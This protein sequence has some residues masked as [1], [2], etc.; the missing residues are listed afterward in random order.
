MECRRWPAYRAPD[1]GVPPLYDSG[2]K[3]PEWRG[4]RKPLLAILLVLLGVVAVAIRWW[5]SYV[6]DGLERWAVEEVTRRTD[7][8]YRLALDQ[9]SFRPLAGAISFDSAAVVT[10][11]TRNRRRPVPLPVLR[12]LAHECRVSGLNLVRLLLAR[13]F[14]AR[15][16]ECRRVV[17]RITINPPARGDTGL[18]T[19]T[20]GIATS[21]RQLA[22]PLG[23]AAFRVAAVSFPSFS[24]TMER[25]G[26][27][28]AATL[29]VERGRFDAEDLA[30]DLQTASADEARLAARGVVLRLGTLTEISF[31]GLVAD[32]TDSTLSL[33]GTEHEPRIP[34]REWVRRLRVRRDRIRF[35]L[36]SL[37]GRGVAYRAFL[38][39][40][41]I[42]VRALELRDARL[43]V[44]TDRRIPAGPPRRHRTPQQAAARADP[45]V[46]MDTVLVS[47][48]SI[49]YREREA[50]T[51]RPG[52][53]SFERLRATVLGLDLPSRGQPLR[54]EASAR[55]MGEGPLSARASVPLDAPDFRYEL[56]GRLGSMPAK[57]FNAFL[58]VNEA[59]QFD[60]GRVEEVTIHQTVRDGR[61]STT[62]V[63]RYRELSIESTG[64]GG[65]VLGSVA[66]GI[67]EF[68][69]GVFEVRSSNPEDED[70]EPRVGRTVRRY[71]PKTK[72]LRFLW[73][74]IR[75]GLLE[76][77]R[78]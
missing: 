47:G 53:V 1:S 4:P 78:E 66:R 59:Y 46:H 72:W 55:L 51:A 36:D 61:A 67:E 14:N 12:G 40:G 54:I 27:R 58:S 44:L 68:V 75:D 10:D 30:F 35:T 49:V 71:D 26:R 57:A 2:V 34:E 76:V 19:D 29:V 11:S 5:D 65:G 13:S 77:L 52:T 31:A 17:A 64:E 56:S 22:R 8:T 41:D 37:H 28:R 62:V 9:L 7:G 60:D 6:E 50:G 38:G 63:P 43:D 24:L 69:A 74:G 20:A 16:L 15:V 73:T 25:P 48:G 33:A 3:I 39:R 42:R 23:I 18:V 45:A 32:L 21:V 70:E